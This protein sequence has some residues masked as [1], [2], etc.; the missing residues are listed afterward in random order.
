MD[1]AMHVAHVAVVPVGHMGILIEEIVP[2]LTESADPMAFKVGRAERALGIGQS[3]D[4]RARRGSQPHIERP[5][6]SLVTKRGTD[7]LSKPVPARCGVR[8]DAD[9]PIP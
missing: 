7:M 2:A 9:V 5:I 3:Y 4:G 1:M 8:Y 6:D